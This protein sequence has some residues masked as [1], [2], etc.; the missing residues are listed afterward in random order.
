VGTNLDLITAWGICFDRGW[1]V[2]EW[3]F[4]LNDAQSRLATRGRFLLEFNIEGVRGIHEKSDLKALFCNFPGLRAGIV[5]RRTV[6]FQKT[7]SA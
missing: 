1:G 4:F 7:R 2:S 5:D 6:L 3:E